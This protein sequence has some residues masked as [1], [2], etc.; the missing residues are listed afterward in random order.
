MICQWAHTY[1]DKLLSLFLKFQKLLHSQTIH[2]LLQQDKITGR[3]MCLMLFPDNARQPQHIRI[4][5]ITRELMT[6]NK[7]NNPD[8]KSESYSIKLHRQSLSQLS[9]EQTR[10]HSGSSSG[11]HP[12][13]SFRQKKHCAVSGLFSH[14]VWINP[15]LAIYRT[16]KDKSIK[17]ENTAFQH[18]QIHFSILTDQSV[19]SRFLECKCSPLQTANQRM[20]EVCSHKS[21]F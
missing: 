19:S 14:G 8:F 20:F 5:I 1:D 13:S 15:A 6:F 12:S 17:D 21:T 18:L 2:S 4:Y 11:S 3:R 9:N 7:S 16:K 10:T